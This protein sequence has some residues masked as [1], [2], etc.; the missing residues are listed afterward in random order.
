M[1]DNKPFPKIILVVDDD[2]AILHLMK[3]QLES[4]GYAV[5]GEA[6]GGEALERI[7]K[8]NFFAVLCD[9]GL[10]DM[11]GFEVLKAIKAMRPGLPVIVVTGNHEEKEGRRAFEL[12]ALEYITKPIDF[13]YLKNILLLN[14]N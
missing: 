11:S 4:E 6:T 7:K 1:P 14:S 3:L 10:P 12:G 5:I 13:N 9:L 8:A 2:Q